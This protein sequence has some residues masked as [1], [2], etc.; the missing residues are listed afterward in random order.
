KQINYA[1]KEK[2]LLTRLKKYRI[3]Y[4]SWVEDFYIPFTYNVSE[5]SLR[6]IKSKMKIAGQFQNITS[7]KN[8]S[9]IR[10]YTETCKRHGLN[11]LD[12][13]QRACEGRNYILN[14]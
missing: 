14:Y 12:A 10:I 11:V 7:A 2:A 4:F 1:Q 8:Y 5:R 9:T 3:E 6:G 13:L